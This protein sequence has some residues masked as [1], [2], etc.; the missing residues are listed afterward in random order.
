L[1]RTLQDEG[2]AA[3]RRGGDIHKLAESYTLGRLRKFPPELNNFKKE[4]VHLKTLHPM[5][6][7]NWGFRSD[8]SWTGRPGWFGDDVWLRVKADAFALY[9]DDT[10]DLI[11]HKT[12]RKYATNDEQVNLFG[13]VAFMR[14]PAL[15]R[16]RI[17]LWYLDVA[18]PKEKEVLVEMT[19][20]EATT[21]RKDWDKKIKPMFND[22]RFAPKPNDKCKWCPASNAN[23]GVCKF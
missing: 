15:K 9:D 1:D 6:E 18:D 7:Q 14:I 11:D 16:V 10:A 2:S 23:G 20:R 3:M 4:F 8:W 12:G 13:A 5:V 19:A 21:V 22:R 17:R